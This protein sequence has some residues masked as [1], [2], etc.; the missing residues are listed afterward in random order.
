ME[1]IHTGTS[2]TQVERIR[3]FLLYFIYANCFIMKFFKHIGKLKEFFSKYLYTHHYI[4]PQYCSLF[5]L[6]HIYPFI[7]PNPFFP[8]KIVS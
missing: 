8:L 3:S 5:V 4:L 7:S 2:M 1:L 6:L